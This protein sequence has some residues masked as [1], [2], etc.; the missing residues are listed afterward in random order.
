MTLHY[1]F[2]LCNLWAQEV[3]DVTWVH[4][5]RN[6]N[7]PH[8]HT[9]VRRYV[10]C[11]L[12]E[13]RAKSL[14]RCVEPIWRAGWIAPEQ[15]IMWWF[16]SAHTVTSATPFAPFT[17]RHG[18]CGTTRSVLLQCLLMSVFF[19]DC[20]LLSCVCVCV[21]V[22][23]CMIEWGNEASSVWEFILPG[24]CVSSEQAYGHRDGRQPAWL[25]L[26]LPLRHLL[27]QNR[28]HAGHGWRER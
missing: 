23:V 25:R 4:T 1:Y 13:Y 21:C 12:C 10:Q 18:W 24:E 27:D 19:P 11:M 6:V 28:C 8:R 2:N 16:G 3:A 22:C 7:P 20:S 9:C 14:H 5:L 26:L 15:S 17:L